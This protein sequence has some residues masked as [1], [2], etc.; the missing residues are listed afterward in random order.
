MRP[1]GSTSHSASRKL[2]PPGTKPEMLI[3]LIADAYN[4][5]TVRDG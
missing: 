1:M 2:L 5:A 3:D 4:P